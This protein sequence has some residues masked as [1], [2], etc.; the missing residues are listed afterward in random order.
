MP[1]IKAKPMK[2][3]KI[4]NADHLYLTCKGDTRWIPFDDAI[5]Y[6]EEILTKINYPSDSTHIV[7]L[8]RDGNIEGE[9]PLCHPS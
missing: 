2:R 7:W 1:F 5:T 6:D 4:R 9:S 3:F 8:D